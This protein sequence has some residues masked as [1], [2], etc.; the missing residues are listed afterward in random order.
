MG[1]DPGGG[2]LQP[3]VRPRGRVTLVGAGPGAADLLTLRGLRKL[4]EADLVLYDALSSEEMRAYA[5]VARWFYVGKRACRQSIGQDVLNRLM[6][7]EAMRGFNVVRLKC[8]DPFV[9][10]RGGEELLA[11]AAAGIPCEVVPGVSSSV[12]GPLLAGIP[13]THRGAASAFTVV[14]GHHEATFRPLLATLPSRGMTLVVLMGL[15]QRSALS[16]ALLEF[17]WSPGTPCA[18]VL[19]AATP[20]SWSWRGS[21]AAVADVA[22][23][24]GEVDEAGAPGL[25]VIGEVVAVADE[26]ERLRT[27]AA[28]TRPEE[29]P[30]DDASVEIHAPQNQVHGQGGTR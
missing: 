14:A 18:I 25:L 1:D 27:V 12:A 17:G 10:G 9:F 11:L 13:V 30:R 22:L 24:P 26:V 16:R 6:I 3:G 20:Q 28:V 5:P 2:P 15:R 4:G 29:T 8:G 23:P 7:R 19:G 21:L